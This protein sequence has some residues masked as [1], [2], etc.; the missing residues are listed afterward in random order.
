VSFI[1]LVSGT[2][3]AAGSPTDP[4]V[5]AV[6][7]DPRGPIADAIADVWWWLLIVGAAVYVVVMAALVVALLRRRD[8]E[9][10]PLASRRVWILGGGVV[11][12]SL[13]LAWVLGLSL[14]SM[15]ALPSDTPPDAVVVDVVAHQWWW[16]VRY[17][18]H[19]FATAN[20]LHIP[21]GEDV[22]VR[23]ISADVIHSFW[24][25]ALA[26]KID[27]LPDGP[28][29]IILH[30]EAPGVYRGQCA[31]FCGLQ[32]AKMGLLVVAEPPGDFAAWLA[33][34]PVAASPPDGEAAARG[35]ELI[36][37]AGCGECHS[38]RGTQLAGAGGPD[39]THV[40]GRRTIAA[41]TLTNTREHLA[42]WLRDPGAFK[43]GTQMPA[44]ELGDAGLDAVVA[45]LSGLE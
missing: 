39:L 17:R 37:D 32:H 15:A 3:Q 11:I 33:R 29:T 30:A 44:A 24:V 35:L 9:P 1:L 6:G 5:V 45:Y 22:E 38:I 18:G 26:G 25:P 13:V 19:G 41:T 23:V 7:L 10:G 40:A 28:N 14:R 12:P 42:E 36:V 4:S 27:A 31:E 20:E 16:E 34:Q 43:E 21:V 8:H 2:S